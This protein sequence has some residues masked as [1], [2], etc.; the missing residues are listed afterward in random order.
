MDR[1]QKA[2][3]LASVFHSRLESHSHRFSVMNEVEAAVHG[4]L[5][6]R[7]GPLFAEP[8]KEVR[9]ELRTIKTADQDLTALTAKVFPISVDPKTSAQEN[10]KSAER[11][12]KVAYGYNNGAALRM[13]PEM[14]AIMFQLAQHQVRFA[15]GCLVAY[16]DYDKKLIFFHVV[17]PRNHLPPVGWSPYSPAPLDESMICYELPLGEVKRRFPGSMTQLDQVYQRSTFGPG[18]KRT[19]DDKMMVK[20]AMSL[21]TESWY[22]STVNGDKTVVLS[23]SE[24]G[25]RNHPGVCP[26]TSFMQFGS[27]PLFTGQIGIEVALQKVMS[28]EI[29]GT[30]QMLTGPIFVSGMDGDINWTGVNK[31]STL[32]GEKPM[33][34][35]LGPTSPLNTERVLSSLV[36]FARIFNRNPESFQGGGDANSAKAVQTLQAG[37]RSTVQDILWM[38]FKNG[39]PRVYDNCMKMERNLWPNEKKTV[40]GKTGRSAFEIDYVP[41][42]HLDGFDGRV[43]IEFGFGLGGIQQ[44]IEAIQKNGAGMLSKRTAIEYDMGVRD[45]DAEMR[46]IESEEMGEV[47]TQVMAAKGELLS[48]SALAAIIKK[49]ESGKTKVEAITEAEEEGLFDPPPVED[50][51]MAMAGGAPPPGGLPPELAAMMGGG[52]GM[53]ASLPPAGVI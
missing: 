32:G 17:D 33:V 53:P 45:V 4:R 48:L 22:A 18:G 51:M 10:V 44:S 14:D 8:E 19:P 47:L 7:Y 27:D 2:Q 23:Q 21:G 25:D 38:P 12:E 29:R 52:G 50:P 43:K 13:G 35:R 46:R 30:E 41:S 42:V 1:P 40:R 3:D 28:Q 5:P 39:F 49:I 34:Q 9:I 6:E 36:N 15:D 31:L 24:A 20:F 11:V 16:P 26:I 37:V